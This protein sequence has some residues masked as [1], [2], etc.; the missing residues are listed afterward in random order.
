MARKSKV[1]RP[2]KELK[3]IKIPIEDWVFINKY[4]GNEKTLHQGIHEVLTEYREL[5][6]TFEGGNGDKIKE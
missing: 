1:G 5:E 3:T 6:E 4:C 2:R